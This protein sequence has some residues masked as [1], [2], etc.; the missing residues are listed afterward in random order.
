MKFLEDSCAVFM[1]HHYTRLS[2][3]HKKLAKHCWEL[4]LDIAKAKAEAGAI[5]VSSAKKTK[6]TGNRWPSDISS[7]PFDD[8][9][10][11]MIG[12][13]HEIRHRDDLLAAGYA[14]PFFGGDEVALL[15]ATA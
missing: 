11:A 13:C 15:D 4:L 6:K 10:R 2:R 9:L 3:A 14:R 12:P 8:A 1:S 7:L 5:E